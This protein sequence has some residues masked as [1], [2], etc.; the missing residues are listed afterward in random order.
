M[1]S[2]TTV[3]HCT[4]GYMKRYAA[5]LSPMIDVL[6]RGGGG[7]F[8]HEGTNGRWRD[9]LSQD[10]IAKFDR[11]ALEKLGPECAHWLATGEMPAV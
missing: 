2:S 6:F 4:F 11:I 3:E 8:I 10:D 9:V 7:T 5:A 1:T